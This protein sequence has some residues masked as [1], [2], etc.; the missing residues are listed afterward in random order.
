VPISRSPY[1]FLVLVLALSITLYGCAR[2]I[3]PTPNRELTAL[4]PGNYRI[5]P[6]HTA[7]LFKVWHL[8]LSKLVGR[9]N[10]V[11]ASLD[12]DPSDLGAA[13]LQAL[14][15]IGSIDVV[16]PDLENSLTSVFWLDTTRYPTASFTSTSVQPLDTHTI[17]IKGELTFMGVTRPLELQA[18]FNGGALNVLSG[19]YTIGFQAHGSLQRSDF[20]LRNYLPAVGDEVAL[21]VH[22]EFQRL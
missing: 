1:R 5:D 17:E 18:V 15:D 16:N 7:V 10:R 3:T 11:D 21:E 9:F 13:R 14:V 6:D 4:R 2:L 8:G 20:G 12:F 19:K 22:A